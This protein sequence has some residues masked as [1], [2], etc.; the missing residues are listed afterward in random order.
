MNEMS[1]L[2]QSTAEQEP[3]FL[4][5]QLTG[6]ATRPQI[7]FD[8]AVGVILPILCLI[9]DPIVFRGGFAG[10]GVLKDWQLFAY[11]VITLEV[12]TLAVW[13]AWGARAGAWLSAI[14]AIMLAGALFSFVIALVILP[15][16]I[17]GL[18][19][20]FI[21]VLGFTPFL[22]GF[23]YLRNG[24]RALR[25]ASS[26]SLAGPLLLGMVF[27]L[28]VPAVAQW[29]VSRML[30]ESVEGLISEDTQRQAA[31]TSRLKYLRWI[32]SDDLDDLVW[33]YARATDQAHKERL[34]TTYRALTGENIEHRLF[35]LND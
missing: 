33:A 32:A 19:F 30:T 25:T 14:G 15:V 6:T 10:E 13:L 22:T 12:V 1:I 20:Y 31:A 34:A 8:L 27:V 2:A 4:R 29:K 9:F 5:R 17:I 21:G 3:R 18:I 7:I 28:G 35:I 24:R 23:V 16:S 26:R 11:I